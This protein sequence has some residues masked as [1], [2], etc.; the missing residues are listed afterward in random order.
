[1]TK[2]LFRV[3]ANAK[4]GWGHFYRCLALAKMLA[5]NFQISFAV[6]APSQSL[7]KVIIESGFNLIELK[8]FVYTTPDERI[9]YI[10][11]DLGDY[12]KGVDIVV[13]DGYWFGLDYCRKLKRNDVYVVMIEDDGGG[14]Y[15][16]DLIINHAPGVEEKNY[17]LPSNCFGTALG[18]KY[19]LLRPA[20][21]QAMT[22]GYEVKNKL[23]KAVISFGGADFYNL[24]KL[25]LDWFVKHTKVEFDVVIGNS[26]AYMDSLSPFIQN[27]RVKVHQGLS[28][29]EMCQLMKGADFGVLP[30]SGLLFEAIA[31]RL[32]IISGYYAD[33]QLKIFNGFKA[34]HA[35]VDSNK[36]KDFASAWKELN[37]L[38]LKSIQ[39][40]HTHIIDSQV[41]GRY[42]NLFKNIS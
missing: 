33:N 12:A 38:E 37:L 4:I 14:T 11:F 24:T 18:P 2:I 41:K 15:E 7:Q 32:P 30:A 8:A 28:E 20:F 40:R 26:Y 39:E 25:T 13:L 16:V 5:D 31:M 17:V 10:P 27:E 3:D 21:L 1:M 36:F 42:Q 29:I 34:L 22:N 35:F 19:A 9:G 6:S 23:K